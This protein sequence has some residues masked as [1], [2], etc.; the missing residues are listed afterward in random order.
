MEIVTNTF[1]IVNTYEDKCLNQR[2]KAGLCTSINSALF[3]HV[4]S[5]Q[6]WHMCMRCNIHSNAK[7]EPLLTEETLQLRV[8]A[9]V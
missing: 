1:D 7:S 6:Q 5:S 9:L 4:N 3:M 8:A 2:I